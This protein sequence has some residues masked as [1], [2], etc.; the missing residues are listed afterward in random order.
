MKKHKL[1][2]IFLL[3]GVWIV[4]S[5]IS[6][7]YAA[8]NTK[9]FIEGNATVHVD[10]N[11]RI[12]NLKLLNATNGGYE[13]YNSK[14][15]KNTITNG[16]VLPNDNSTISY[17]VAITNKENQKYV[18]KNIAVESSNN[19]NINF[20]TNY[21]ENQVIDEN[22]TMEVEVM[23]KT[24]LGSENKNAIILKF[25]FLKAYVISFDANEGTVNTL[26]KVVLENETYGELPTPTRRGFR[27]L[28][29]YTQKDGGQKIEST[30]LA[31]IN[32][33][34]TLYAKWEESRSNAYYHEGDY[35]FD[36]TN[37]IDTGVYLF[38]E[39]NITKN[40]EISFEIKSR[41][42]STNLAVMMGAMDETDSPW[43]GLTYRVRNSKED[44]LSANAST[45]SKT[46]RNY[47]VSN[48][49]KVSIKRFNNRIY[50]SFNDGFDTHVIDFSSML[51][52]P[53]DVPVTFGAGLDGDFNP[54]RYFKG[55]L[56]NMN[57][58][59]ADDVRT[60][61]YYSNNGSGL[62][63]Q[64]LLVGKDS[65]NLVKNTFTK[66]DY[67]FVGWN[68][69]SD[70]TGIAYNDNDTINF[71]SEE[72][73]IVLYAQW[74]TIGY[75]VK[76]DANGGTGEMVNQEFESGVSQNLQ[77][78]SFTKDGT[79][80]LKWNTRSDGLGTSYYD[81]ESV[82]NLALSNGETVTLYALWGDAWEYSGDNV[83]DGTNYI[84]TGI[85]LFSAQN[86]SKNF[87]ISFEIKSRT[88]TEPYAVMIG[89]MDESGSPW[90]GIVYRTKNETND[91][92]I[93]NSSSVKRE[94][95]YSSSKIQK[96]IIK[97][98]NNGIYISFN[99]GDNVYIDNYS[100]MVS[101]P[102]D[103][104]LTIGAGL[105]GDL[106]PFRYFTGTLSNIK[107]YLFDN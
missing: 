74:D 21:S 27:F 49:Q 61:Q 100:S 7:T 55:T 32:N 105:D 79:Q 59:I 75:T 20:E 51:S 94:K 8:L 42:T 64:Q 36:G 25:D 68:T 50:I 31:T 80:F 97:R 93:A 43:P 101:K 85:Y 29:W 67:G 10:A 72:E 82:K 33:N 45:S 47:A 69:K 63:Y 71:T 16:I 35:V 11:I 86:I 22:S 54:F 106:N 24:S 48:I 4:I 44:Q 9:M 107:I 104:P 66:T 2:N 37:Y 99:D 88:F 1:T 96:V 46:E 3:C 84:D 70:G 73:T 28:G 18:I 30:T 92:F 78:N 17:N 12:T 57:I 13:T 34:Q 103:V 95:T 62:V 91:H 56:S 26:N 5:F 41:N 15:T 19:E 60:I 52:K 38:S 89:A 98:V 6:I 39:E 58:L 53:F 102:F 87:E 83:F 81:G 76:Y 65:T 40:F 90:P 14:Y 23:Y 77:L